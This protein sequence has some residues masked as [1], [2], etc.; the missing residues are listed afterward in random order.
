MIVAK[1][2]ATGL[3]G[4]D[5][6]VVA[7]MTGADLVD[8]AY[9][10]PFPFVPNDGVAH[11]VRPGDFVSTEDGTGIVHIAPYG[12]DDMII[13]KAH[14]LPIVQIIDRRPRRAQRGDFA[15]LWKRTGQEG[16]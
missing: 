3:L 10:P 15:G 12:E 7:E 13:A 14:D 5:V 8:T 6:E 1:D 9:R 4:E 11:R 2:L 16:P